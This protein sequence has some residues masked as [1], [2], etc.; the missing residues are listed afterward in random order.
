MSSINYNKFSLC[1][2]PT[3]M[4][5][6]FITIKKILDEIENDATKGIS[7]HIVFTMNTLLNNKQFANRLSYINKEHGENAIGVFSSIYKGDLIHINSL[8]KLILLSKDKLKMPKIIV[9]CSN[10]RRFVDCFKYIEYLDKTPSIVRRAFLY[11]DEIHKYISVK[12]T[13]LRKKIVDISDKQILHGILAMTA[14]PDILWK[15]NNNDK[16]DDYWKNIKIINIDEY[17]E[18]NYYGWGDMIIKAKNILI[19]REEE[20]SSDGVCCGAGVCGEDVESLHYSELY[21]IEYARITLKENP[22]ILSEYTK[23][24]IPATRKRKTHDI[25]R[26]MIF[27]INPFAVVVTLNGKEKSMKYKKKDKAFETINLVISTEELGDLIAHHLNTNNLMSRPLVITGYLCVGM[28]QTLVSKNLGPFTSAIF[29]YD[30]INNDTLYQLF[31]RITGRIKTWQEETIKTCVYTTINNSLV[32]KK[33]EEC[34]RNIVYKYNG[35]ILDNEKYR[36]PLE[37]CIEIAKK[38]K[39]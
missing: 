34:A 36:E 16:I 14:T 7:V 21:N 24:F 2:L 12:K 15:K 3:Q 23:T 20:T 37:K 10:H 8:C 13:D 1:V 9:A 38:F 6:T 18:N 19:N 5:K 32:C 31:G 11:F 17:D 4:G 25:M 35:K 33:M 30:N 29:G 26:N 28:G 27:D 39:K 22:D